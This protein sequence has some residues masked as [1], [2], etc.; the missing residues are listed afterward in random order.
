MSVTRYRQV[1]DWA[2]RRIG[3]ET[4]AVLI[5]TAAGLVMLLTFA[6]V[7]ID[8]SAVY[9][10][11][12]HAQTAA[13][14]AALAGAQYANVDPDA[15][16]AKLVII[17][18]VKAI[19]A[20][21][22][23]VADW[24]SCTDSNMPPEFAPVSGQTD[25]I[26]FTFGLTKIRVRI[27]DQ[28]FPAFFAKVIG[29]DTLTANAS[30]EV[31]AL[32]VK[33]GD[34]LPFGIPTGDASAT[35]GCPSDHP[36]GVLPCDGPDAGNFNRLQIL[37]WGTDPPPTNNCTHSNSMFEDNIADGVDHPLGIYHDPGNLLVDDKPTCE[38]AANVSRPPGTIESN[39]GVAQSTLA[40]GL[41]TG[42]T[43]GSGFDGRLVD[44]Q[45]AGGQT[46]TV[47][48]RTVDNRPLWD[49][50]G[51]NTSGI[52]PICYAASFDNDT[53]LPVDWDAELWDPV[54]NPEPGYDPADPT[55]LDNV[56]EEAESFEHMAACLR[57]YAKV[58]STGVLFNKSDIASSSDNEVGV[59][60]LQLSPRWGW[61]P[62]GDFS[63]GVKPFR[64]SRFVPVFVNSLV[65]NCTGNTCTWIWHAGDGPTS[66]STNGNRI[67][68][69]VSFQ[70]PR[71][72]LPPEVFEF[73][74]D[75]EIET[76]YTL[77]K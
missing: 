25:C 47:L 2:R 18:K 27:P 42:N 51:T 12:R 49:Y 37:Q 62:V 28:T 6:A 69:M 20:T 46:T 68:S 45:V 36:N 8:I 59:Y 9:T 75:S 13:D 22:L 38:G 41:I 74:P 16:V 63:T 1:V 67:Q 72:T 70:L 52:P 15:D 39:T 10:T 66:S 50:I 5:F 57:E 21:N 60:D 24:D 48:S 65:A 23:E 34:I 55:N 54:T 19:T 40:P 29:V 44:T 3:N 32:I 30:A 33:N 61:S 56:S 58:G 7:A 11:R 73:G 77:T 64:I 76:E 53:N 43:G 26:S 4:G 31:E 71:T 14:V 17:D 35:L